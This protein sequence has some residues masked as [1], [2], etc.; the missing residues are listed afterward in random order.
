VAPETPFADL[1]HGDYVVHADYGVGRFEGLVTRTLDESLREFLLV[2]YAEGDQL[3]VP[4]H[5]VD[6]LTRYL[7]VD[8]VAPRLSRLGSQ[9][10]ERSRAQAQRA[11]EEVAKELLDLYARRLTVVGHAFSADSP[12]SS[13]WRP[14]SVH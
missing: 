1:S 10:W 11:V 2:S 8:G 4:I 6:R 3:Y 9:E 14:L 7:G 13:S 12:D 5:Q